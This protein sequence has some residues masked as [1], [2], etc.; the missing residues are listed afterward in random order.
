MQK[1]TLKQCGA[2]QLKPNGIG[3]VEEPVPGGRPTHDVC[4]A[5][6]LSLAQTTW[7][8]VFPDRLAQLRT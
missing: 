5:L 3:R 8:R 2:K 4:S 7:S 1:R 6:A